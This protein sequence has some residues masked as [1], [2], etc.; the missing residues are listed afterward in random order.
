MKL[1]NNLQKIRKTL[2]EKRRKKRLKQKARLKHLKEM[3]AERKTLRKIYLRELKKQR[4]RKYRAKKKAKKE[5][6]ILKKI[7]MKIQETEQELENLEEE[8]IF[9]RR[10]IKYYKETIQA[11]DLR[12]LKKEIRKIKRKWLILKR[13]QSSETKELDG[14]MNYNDKYRNKMMRYRKRKPRIKTF[15]SY[16]TPSQQNIK[17]SSLERTKLGYKMRELKS[18]DSKRMMRKKRSINRIKKISKV[19]DLKR[20][21]L[22]STPSELTK[23]NISGLGETSTDDI[24][25]MGHKIQKK[26]KSK[27]LKA[28]EATKKSLSKIYAKV[29]D[30]D[31]SAEIRDIPNGYQTSEVSEIEMDK[32]MDLNKRKSSKVYKRAT[33]SS[34]IYTK[35]AKQTSESAI[36][37]LK[38]GI[39]EIIRIRQPIEPQPIGDKKEE[40]EDMKRSSRVT[41][42]RSVTRKK[43]SKRSHSSYGDYK[44]PPTTTTTTTTTESNE[45]EV[46]GLEV[47]RSVMKNK[48]KLKKISKAKSSNKITKDISA[49]RENLKESFE[50]DILE[51]TDQYDKP[52]ND[53][54]VV[55]V[56]RL[57]LRLDELRRRYN[58]L[59]PRRKLKWHFYRKPVDERTLQSISVPKGLKRLIFKP[60]N[61]QRQSVDLETEL[62][63]QDLD[64]VSETSAIKEEVEKMYELKS[65]IC[66][67]KIKEDKILSFVPRIRKLPSME[68]DKL[69]Q[70]LI[71]T[72][73]VINK[74]RSPRKAVTI[75]E[76]KEE[77]EVVREAEQV[78]DFVGEKEQDIQT[79]FPA[80]AKEDKTKPSLD[81]SYRKSAKARKPINL[82]DEQFFPKPLK[83]KKKPKTQKRQSEMPRKMVTLD[84]SDEDLEEQEQELQSHE[85]P[86]PIAAVSLYKLKDKQI[87]PY[88]PPTQPITPTQVP[89]L[90][91]PKKSS[92]YDEKFFQNL[93]KTQRAT[94][95]EKLLV[96]R[97]KQQ[98]LAKEKAEREE[99]QAREY[100]RKSRAN[101]Y[102][103]RSTSLSESTM[104]D[105]LI[106][107]AM[108]SNYNLAEVIPTNVPIVDENLLKNIHKSHKIGIKDILSSTDNDWS[109]LLKVS[110]VNLK[111]DT[112][113]NVALLPTTSAN[114]LETVEKVQSESVTSVK[115]E[116]K[117]EQQPKSIQEVQFDTLSFDELVNVDDLIKSTLARQAADER[118]LVTKTKR[119]KKSKKIIKELEQKPSSIETEEL[120]IICS[121]CGMTSL[122]PG[123]PCC[124]LIMKK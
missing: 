114:I 18:N 17:E 24:R 105:N 38:E 100:Y 102:R 31:K 45:S 94:I 3:A 60:R 46:P 13:M 28:S 81:T 35:P 96:Q 30:T 41:S 118:K 113:L 7:R 95:T 33:R 73:K 8:E 120:R 83:V 29:E 90:S 34:T 97:K 51:L 21:E 68:Q 74:E 10:Q 56:K 22:S 71:K 27:K 44:T 63:E 85:E 103:R 19:K 116:I 61:L 23:T 55:R 69:N 4:A 106:K 20:S 65:P 108:K 15:K 64:K 26:L 112:P 39:K 93:V 82:N 84:E 14:I 76:S 77:P 117:M 43:K 92:V 78:G 67:Y 110:Q 53:N 91:K 72:E 36:E 9:M 89:P 86:K 25:E 109:S 52:L 107:S 122:Q 47:K 124:P 5:F 99:E 37:S 49:E 48:A 32:K 98:E 70:T 80:K 62:E 79:I 1:K 16:K 115:E 54:D 59:K 11:L 88:L 50:A 119:K 121:S 2:R 58:Q 66:L 40:S 87:I 123:G 42:K 12:G 57:S 104:M 111:V 75:M 6:L 101:L